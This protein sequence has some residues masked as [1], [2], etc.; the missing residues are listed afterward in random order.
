MHVWG[1]DT[2]WVRL[3][4]GCA[5]FLGVRDWAFLELIGSPEECAREWLLIWLYRVMPNLLW[6]DI[7]LGIVKKML[8]SLS[9]S[10]II[11][12]PS[13]NS[14]INIHKIRL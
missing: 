11:L 7:I 1:S 5:A 4:D 6:M 3:K 9:S 2:L 14:M 8:G 10:I 13:S 12:Y